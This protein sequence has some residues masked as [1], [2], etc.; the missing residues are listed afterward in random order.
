MYRG[1][2]TSV[3]QQSAC[4]DLDTR[5]ATPL[6]HCALCNCLIGKH[7]SKYCKPCAADARVQADKRYRERKRNA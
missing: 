3:D 5:K 7:R 4:G 6:R 1:F 2:L